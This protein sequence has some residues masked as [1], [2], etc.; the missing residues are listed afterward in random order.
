MI[1][2]D[3]RVDKISSLTS[4]LKIA[5][6]NAEFVIEVIEYDSEHL[7]LQLPKTLGRGL[8]VSLELVI[9]IDGIDKSMTATGK[10]ASCEG[11]PLGGF[12]AL[13][14]LHEYN[15][16]LWEEFLASKKI[17]RERVDKLL[18]SMKGDE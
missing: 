3:L 15:H 1:K 5:V 9:K 18:R 11:M 12:F 14:E 8:L 4:N 7:G 16:E 17:E 13:I 10:I 2:T 6:S